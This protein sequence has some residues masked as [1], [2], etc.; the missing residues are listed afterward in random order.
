MT[1]L[2]TSD[3]M[4]CSIISAK[5]NKIIACV[6][7]VAWFLEEVLNYCAS[8]SE[9]VSRHIIVV[10][11]VVFWLITTYSMSYQARPSI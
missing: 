7:V 1:V 11:A 3:G 6:A 10:I 4:F 9:Q 2:N 8:R 5:V